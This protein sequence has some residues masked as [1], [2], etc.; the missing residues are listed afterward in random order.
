MVWACQGIILGNNSTDNDRG[1][2]SGM[3]MAI[4]MFGSVID[5]LSL[6]LMK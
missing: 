3:F 4:Y 1:T 2:K 6:V 5:F